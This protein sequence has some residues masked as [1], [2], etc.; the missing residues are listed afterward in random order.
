MTGV[1]CVCSPL[2]A[3][4]ESAVLV[5]TSTPPPVMQEPLSA[6]SGNLPLENHVL[7]LEAREQFLFSKFYIFIALQFAIGTGWLQRVW[8]S[9]NLCASTGADTHG[10]LIFARSLLFSF[11]CCSTLALVVSHQNQKEK[12]KKKKKNNVD[13]EPPPTYFKYFKW[14]HNNDQI[15]FLN[16]TLKLR[17]KLNNVLLRKEMSK[18][19]L[20]FIVFVQKQRIKK[21][22]HIVN[23]CFMCFSLDLCFAFC[24]RSTS[25][26]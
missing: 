16:T 12:R 24:T 18:R 8:E 6:C 14:R 17:G 19:G 5:G 3:I 9:F 21:F 22:F 23:V 4:V 13:I 2:L 10:L 26:L 7:P 1:S 15:A 11:G 25:I 20:K